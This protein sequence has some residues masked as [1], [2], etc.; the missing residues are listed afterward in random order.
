MISYRLPN[1]GTNVRTFSLGAK[2]T[3]EAAM[4]F[5]TRIYPKATIVDIRRAR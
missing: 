2:S 4:E 1:E 3:L 5:T